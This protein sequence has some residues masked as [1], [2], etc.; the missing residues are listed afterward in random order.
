MGIEFV[1]SI[2]LGQIISTT[3]VV[4]IVAVVFAMQNSKATRRLA[5]LEVEI[6]VLRESVRRLN[7]LFEIGPRERWLKRPVV[8]SYSGSKNWNNA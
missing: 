3:V 7:Q 2:S 8:K 5:A 1:W 6:N 4:F